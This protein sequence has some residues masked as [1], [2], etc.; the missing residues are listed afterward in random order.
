MSL[1]ARCGGARRLGGFLS[2]AALSAGLVQAA[3]AQGDPP[4]TQAAL[5]ALHRNDCAGAVDQLNKGVAAGEAA[6]FYWAG[7]MTDTGSCVK[8]DPVHA[9]SYF[10]S[11]AEKESVPAK[12]EL[13]V[14]MGL[15]EGI[16]QNYES[17]GKLFRAGGFDKDSH[18]GLYTL[19]YA[20]TLRKVAEKRAWNA[21]PRDVLERG[22][23]GTVIVE[24]RA[25][26]GEL[27]TR[28]A[29]GSI[30][31][32]DAPTGSHLHNSRHDIIRAVEDSWQQ[33]VASAP[34]PDAARLDSG[35]V[36][37]R[38]DLNIA[39]EPLSQLTVQ[40]TF[41]LVPTLRGKAG[42]SGG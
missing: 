31:I 3:V 18:V 35:W 42:L 23:G 10:V 36:E 5:D 25:D 17:A 7:R 22:D 40:Q 41:N 11:A 20:G 13:G 32:S 12:V 1:R 37:L 16:E 29:P 9:T 39:A 4:F 33:A 8:A 14:K 2:A 24:F 30:L 28:M 34:K 27:R 19:G 26:T 21:L 6:A 38:V 15:G